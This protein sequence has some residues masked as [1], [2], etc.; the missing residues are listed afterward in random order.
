[1]AIIIVYFDI[2]M[3]VWFW[4]LILSTGFIFVLESDI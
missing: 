3:Y 2:Y 1:M 4:E